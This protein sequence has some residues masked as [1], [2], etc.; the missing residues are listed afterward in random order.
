MIW[1][2]TTRSMISHTWTHFSFMLNRRL[3]NKH[4]HTT[5]F[6][7]SKKKYAIFFF[8]VPF[9]HKF[10]LLLLTS[11]T[12]H[13]ILR[14]R[15]WF[16]FYCM[17]PIWLKVLC[18]LAILHSNCMKHSKKNKIRLFS[19]YERIRHNRKLGRHHRRRRFS[20]FLSVGNKFNSE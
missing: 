3:Q 7:F 18:R 8:L 10:R 13:S 20:L 19:S 12:K 2:H 9:K 17:P 11:T 14:M 15:V 6:S 16:L 1:A 4:R 5:L